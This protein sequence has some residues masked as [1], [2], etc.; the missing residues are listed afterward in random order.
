MFASLTEELNINSRQNFFQSVRYI[1]EAQ[2][3]QELLI[4]EQQ[5]ERNN[6]RSRFFQIDHDSLAEE[7]FVKAFRYY[8]RGIIASNYFLLNWLQHGDM[9]NLVDLE[10]MDETISEFNQSGGNV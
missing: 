7:N 2:T 5:A 1:S 6:P 10:D 3:I 8:T 9:E 4:I